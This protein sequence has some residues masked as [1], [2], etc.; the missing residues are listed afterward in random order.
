MEKQKFLVKCDEKNGIARNDVLDY[1][2]PLSS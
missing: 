1:T 2:V